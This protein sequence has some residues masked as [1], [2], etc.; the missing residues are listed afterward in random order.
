MAVAITAFSPGGPDA[1]RGGAARRSPQR[2][3]PTPRHKSR[4]RRAGPRPGRA[5]LHAA[6]LPRPIPARVAVT[7]TR[8]ALHARASRRTVDPGRTG[9]ARG[10][11]DF[12]S[13]AVAALRWSAPRARRAEPRATRR[14]ASPCSQRSCRRVLT[15]APR[16]RR[17]AVPR[18]FL[19]A[20]HRFRGRA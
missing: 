18:A 20:K 3:P 8:R 19:T 9:N 7:R 17:P 14:Q 1:R 11:R 16:R 10:R 4:L 6:P 2:A 5:P 15:R 13:A 12:V